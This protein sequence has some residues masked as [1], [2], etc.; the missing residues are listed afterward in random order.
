MNR[1]TYTERIQ[2]ATERH[3]AAVDTGEFVTWAY[4]FNA[5]MFAFWCARSAA[6]LVVALIVAH[7][8][9]F[10]VWYG[11]GFWFLLLPTVGRLWSYSR[12]TSVVEAHE[13][14]ADVAEQQ[15]M[16]AHDEM[17]AKRVAANLEPKPLPFSRQPAMSGGPKGEA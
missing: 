17:S 12:R 3:K 16:A 13:L 14:S 8:T 6:I 5:G 11:F 7:A 15:A 1:V 10:P 9:G 4:L 2:A